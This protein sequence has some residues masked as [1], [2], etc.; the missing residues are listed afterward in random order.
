[1]VK[2][3]QDALVDSEV[4]IGVPHVGRENLLVRWVVMVTS[5]FTILG[6]LLG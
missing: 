4:F 6:W 3:V 5:F 1:M 2:I